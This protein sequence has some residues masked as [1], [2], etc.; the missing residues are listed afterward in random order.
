MDPIHPRKLALAI[1]ISF[2]S[3][4]PL[5]AWV[6]LGATGHLSGFVDEEQHKDL[7]IALFI[8]TTVWF[9]GVTPFL[10]WPRIFNGTDARENLLKK[11]I[12]AR[13]I[14]LE[15]GLVGK[16][17]IRYLKR[18]NTYLVMAVKVILPD[19]TY[20]IQ[21]HLALVPENILPFVRE[22][23]EFPVR[24]NPS[25]RMNIEIDW[26]PLMVHYPGSD[27]SSGQ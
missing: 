19:D 11:G 12:P 17:G 13:G 21:S 4:M 7:T 1:L 18:R 5:V 10:I 20:E 15:T 14:V 26:E 23:M 16:K 25:N 6:Y 2:F 27:Y 22:G 3:A 24:V 8:V 9:V